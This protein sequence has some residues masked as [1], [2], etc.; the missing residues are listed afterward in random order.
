[1]KRWIAIIV[2]SGAFLGALFGAVQRGNTIK[3]QEEE[4]HLLYNKVDSL[5]TRCT[6]EQ[7]R[8][9]VLDSLVMRALTT[10]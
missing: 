5:T 7:N 8:A 2:L 6:Y 10:N 3:A 4:L 9:D 1:M